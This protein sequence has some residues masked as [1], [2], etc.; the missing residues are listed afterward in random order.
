MKCNGNSTWRS[1]LL[2]LTIM[3]ATSGC[4]HVSTTPPANS[5]C[6]IAKPIRYDSRIDR[7]ATVAQIEEHNSTWACLCDQDCPASGLDTR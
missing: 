5:Y 1:M 2:G 7:P 4:A 6:A 3:T